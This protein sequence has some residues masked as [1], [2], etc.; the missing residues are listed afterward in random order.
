MT[1]LQLVALIENILL[2]IKEYS[3]RRAK[4]CSSPMP[5]CQVM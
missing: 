4:K 2:D 5:R 1:R 3:M